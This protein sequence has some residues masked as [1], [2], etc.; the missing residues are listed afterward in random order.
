[1]STQANGTATQGGIASSSPPS[2]GGA[3]LMISILAIATNLR[4][5]LTS[6]GPLVDDIRNS[7]GMSNAEAG[8]LTTLPLLIFAV[9]AILAPGIDRRFGDRLVLFCSAAVLTAGI[10]VRSLAGIGF[11]FAGTFLIGIAISMCNVLIPAVVKREFP[12]RLGLLTGLYTVSMNTFGAIASGVSIPLAFGLGLGWARALVVWALPG[13]IAV[14]L[15][16]PHLKNNR[17]EGDPPG[18]PARGVSPAPG[19]KTG[20][21]RSR[22]AWWVTVFMGMQALLYYSLVAWLPKIFVFRGVSPSDAGWLLSLMQLLLIPSAFFGSVLAGR[23]PDQRGLVAVACIAVIAGLG[24]MLGGGFGF[25]APWVVVLGVGQGM[26]FGMAMMFFS[27][28]TG[29][30]AEAAQLSGMAQ[31]VG[32]LL[33][34]VGPTLLGLLHDL[35]GDWTMPFLFLLAAAA[36]AGVSG[37]MAGKPGKVSP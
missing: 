17:R 15:W 29:S 36:V 7:L 31:S 32:Y 33:A 25:T 24:G 5:P 16:L 23:A 35:S 19:G 20:L 3:L 26:F 22:L 30:A 12:A 9:L 6:V 8:L 21:W 10:V 14:G 11:L 37:V 1:M 13:A 18:S 28:R 27:L 34:A 4:A 2:T